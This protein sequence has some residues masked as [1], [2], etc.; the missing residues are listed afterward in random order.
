[1]TT[2]GMLTAFKGCWPRKTTDI[3]TFS[4][5]QHTKSMIPNYMESKTPI[6]MKI[7]DVNFVKRSKELNP[8]LAK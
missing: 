4:T 7:Y 6:L 1:M 2:P 3:L 5:T 8:W